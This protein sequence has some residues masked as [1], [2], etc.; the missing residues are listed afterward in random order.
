M[1]YINAQMIARTEH[2]ARVRSI[3]PVREDAMWEREEQCK[4]RRIPALRLRAALLAV[5]NTATRS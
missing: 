1:D 2:E 4:R 5:I 3:P